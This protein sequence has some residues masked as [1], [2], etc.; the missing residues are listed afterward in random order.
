[1]V[2]TDVLEGLNPAQREAAEYVQGPLLIVAGPGSGKTRVIVQR[3]AYLVK[4]VGI[5]PYRVGAVTFTNR[6]AREM[7]DRLERLLGTRAQQLTAGTFHALC[8]AILRRDGQH[9]GL[10][11][12]F[13]IYDE[14][15]QRTLIKRAMQDVEV[16]EKK[17]PLRAVQASISRAKSQLLDPEGYRLQGHSYF[18]EVVCRVYD[19]YQELLQ[20]NNAVDFDDLLMKVVR[21]LQGEPDVLHKYQN[22]YVHLLIDELQDT[23]VAQYQ[24]AKLLAAKHRNI[25]VVGDPDQSIYSWRN[26]D[27]RNILSFQKDYPDAKVVNLDQ[28]YRSTKTILEAAHQLIS[29]NEQRLDKGLWTANDQGVPITVSEGFTG[30]EEALLVIQEAERLRREEN[31]SLRD[32]AIMYRVNA[33]SRAFE[34]A[35]LRCGIPYKLVGGV[36]FY[37]RQE[38]KDVLAYLRVVH[39]PYDEVSLARIMN[40]PPRGIGQRTLEE[41]RRWAQARNLP[42]YAAIQAIADEKES[43]AQP[44]H[45]LASRAAQALV[46]FLHLVNDLMEQAK[47]L[48]LVDLTDA[49]LERTGYR[50]HIQEAG[51]GRAEERWENIQELRGVA[52]E[53]ADRSHE[54]ALVT[55]LENTALVSEQDE[56]DRDQERDYLTL[57]TLHQAKGLEYPVVFLTGLEEGVLPHI[58]SFDDP[59]QMEEERRLCYVGMTRAKERLYL[60][61]AFRRSLH[62]SGQPNMPSRFLADIPT[63]LI[64]AATGGAAKTR[65]ASAVYDRWTTPQQQGRP[66]RPQASPYKDGERVRHA[67][68]GEG[69]V[70]SSTSSGADYEVTVAFK[71]D[72]GIKRLLLSYA[73]LEKA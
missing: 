66:E 53:Y 8:A 5:S 10:Q 48:D 41:L 16:D 20:K 33:Q 38:I 69:V 57:I 51:D 34:E 4:V 59:A 14:E 54:E 21:L 49:I 28:N 58:R 7:R 11:R 2:A 39:N 17:F 23:N 13:V 1:M 68:F 22:R 25:C 50:R 6:A 46:N 70:V 43:G 60:M 15:D 65:R 44:P 42:L 55:F 62:G 45:P 71:G 9:V 56:L 31:H 67:T 12:D 37:Q 40:T 27:L 35:C 32:C 26:A 61:R 3:I 73:P 36:R 63:H 72:A 30:E 29:V 24:I 52:R 64:T 47:E 19:R 18:D